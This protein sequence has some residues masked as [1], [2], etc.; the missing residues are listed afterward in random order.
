MTP[1]LGVVLAIT[2]TS[3]GPGVEHA[4]LKL[5]DKPS[6]GDGMLQVVRIDPK[7]AVLELGMASHDAPARSAA[8]W[9]ERKGWVAAIN[10][11][12]YQNDHL[13]NVGF[14]RHG[15]HVN[16]GRWNAYESVLAF[17]PIDK[18]LPAAV[19]LDR[20][21]PGF[22]EQSAKYRSL[23]QNLRL[24]KGSGVNVWQ[25]NA[26]RWSEAAIAMDKQGR[27]LFLFTR[28]P[29]EMVDF[30]RRLLALPLDIVRAMHV[31]GGP[32]ASLSVRAAGV[33]LD[34]AGSNETAFIEND[35][36]GAQ[37]SLPNVLGVRAGAATGPLRDAQGGLR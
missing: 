4:A 25:P 21:A 3:L 37:W 22:A 1:V 2:W 24:I 23:V 27:I 18:S 34:L 19:I 36:N 11:G 30:N 12:M 15:S 9:A 20:D 28:T 7:V 35:G 32:E 6:H 13:A 33:K 16:N 17:G 8:A 29:Y 31:E 5:D 10:A 26:R 14:L